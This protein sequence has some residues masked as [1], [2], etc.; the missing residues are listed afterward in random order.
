MGNIQGKLIVLPSIKLDQD[1]KGKVREKQEMKYTRSIQSNN[2]KQLA[3]TKLDITEEEI[4]S[5][6]TEIHM[7]IN[8][9]SKTIQSSKPLKTLKLVCSGKR[10]VGNCN[11]VRNDCILFYDRDQELEL[12]GD[13]VHMS[14]SNDEEFDSE[15]ALWSTAVDFEEGSRFGPYI[16][17]KLQYLFKLKV[18]NLEE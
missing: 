6:Y 10:T 17:G 16:F 8:I 11:I 5:L 2:Y 18:P 7:L 14:V 12:V 15:V 1:K 4:G 3:G 9:R 13:V